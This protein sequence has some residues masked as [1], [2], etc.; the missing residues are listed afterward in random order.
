MEEVCCEFHPPQKCGPTKCPE[1]GE[2]GK[3]VKRLTLGSL[4]KPELRAKIPL[5]NE[6]CFCRNPKCDVV[7]LRP[8]EIIFRKKD[9]SVKVGIKE[10]DDSTVSV[11]YCFGWTPQKIQ[12]EIKTTGRT[13]AIERIKTQV[14]AGNC[15]CEVTNPQGACCLGNVTKAVQEAL[16]LVSGGEK[17]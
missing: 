15:Y 16:A 10:P 4:I 2:L 17:R 13:T 6:F 7:Y 14:K 9:L 8:G 11:C 5:Q 12:E 1:C 3:T